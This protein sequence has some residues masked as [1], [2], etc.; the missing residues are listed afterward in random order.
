[1]GNDESEKKQIIDFLNGCIYITKKNKMKSSYR[2]K[3]I[4]F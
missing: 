1:M 4:C 2:I 3:L